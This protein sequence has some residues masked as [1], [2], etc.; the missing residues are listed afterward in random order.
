MDFTIPDETRMMLDAHRKFVEQE[1]LPLE[2]KH[3]LE[4][5]DPDEELPQDLVKQVRKRSGELGF[6]GI[7][8]PEEVGGGGLDNRGISLLREQ[9]FSF[10][11]ALAAISLAGPEGPS[12]ILMD[13]NDEQRKKFVEP[14]VRGQ[15]SSAFALTEPGAGSDAQS[16]ATR[17]VR[18][19]DD[20]ILNGQ[21]VFRM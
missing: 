1:L 10:G 16:I 6:Y 21:K 4:H 11:S 13:A 8:M 17:A 12:Q 18:D 19:G 3:G 20:Y 2:R 15:I 7:F 9:A 14:L 5:R